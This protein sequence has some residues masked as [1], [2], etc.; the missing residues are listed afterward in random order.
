MNWREKMVI[1]ILMLVAE[2]MADG[3][4]KKEVHA[5]ALHLNVSIPEVKA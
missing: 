5:L 3:E 4:W 1:R 2:F